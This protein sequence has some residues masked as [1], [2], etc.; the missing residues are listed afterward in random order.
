[1]NIADVTA[2]VAAYGLIEGDSRLPAAP[3]GDDEWQELVALCRDERLVFLLDAAVQGGAVPAT[4]EQRNELGAL[5][6]PLMQQQLHLEAKLRLVVE[7]LESHQ[8]DHRL[9][10]GPALANTVYADPQ[11][12]YFHDIDLLVRIEQ[13]ADVVRVLTAEAGY[14]RR[15]PELRPGFDRRFAKSVTMLDSLE[16]EL[17]VHRTLVRGV[18]GFELDLDDVWASARQ[19]SVAGVTV[20]ALS[21]EHQLL[22]ATLV[23]ALSDV[24][25]RLSTLRDVAQLASVDAVGAERL[26]VL[27]AHHGVVV[28]VARGV[29]LTERGLQISL[30]E[31]GTWAAGVEVDAHGRRQL[32][33]YGADGRYRQQAFDI[34]RMLPWVD[35]IRYLYALAL[36]SR[37]FLRGQGVG[38]LAWLRGVRN[39][40]G[41]AGPFTI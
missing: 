36:P 32:A 37:E 34:A 21:P 35:R 3:L 28:P 10:K 16:G 13:L 27:A 5:F 25:A 41:P 14:R 11:Q 17:D 6:V 18:C 26:A 2:G 8:L 9:L 1:M 24:P 22:H 30:G 20:K 33:E 38:R 19:V 12:R 40:D 4:V 31:L 29:L 23:A 15:A 7:V 39:P